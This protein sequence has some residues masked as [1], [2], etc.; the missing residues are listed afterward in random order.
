M[1][2]S[3]KTLRIVNT[4][5]LITV[6][7]IVLLALVGI[8]VMTLPTFDASNVKQVAGVPP[9]HG[10]VGLV[11]GQGIVVVSDVASSTI[12]VRADGVQRV[13]GLA[14]GIVISGPHDY[15][16]VEN[17]GTGIVSCKRHCFFW[18]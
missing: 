4:A 13:A 12:T 5:T 1:N 2:S 14:P 11:G 7:V 17:N 3:T 6:G 10:N 15:P 16:V 8:T 9:N 18:W